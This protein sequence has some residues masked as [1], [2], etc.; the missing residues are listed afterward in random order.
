MATNSTHST[1]ISAQPTQ[2][3][4]ATSDYASANSWTSVRTMALPRQPTLPQKQRIAHWQEVYGKK[5]IKV[6]TPHKVTGN[7]TCWLES[8]AGKWRWVL[9]PYGYMVSATLH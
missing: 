6:E 2:T 7:V 5:V 8:M 4:C 9:D 3:C 1:C